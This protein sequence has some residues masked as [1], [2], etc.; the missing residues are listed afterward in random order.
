MKSTGLIQLVGNLHQAGKIHNLRQIC[1]VFGCVL[2]SGMVWYDMVWYGMI[3]DINKQQ[4]FYSLPKRNKL[5]NKIRRFEQR[6]FV[7]VCSLR[8][9]LFDVV[10]RYL[11][12]PQ[13]EASY[14]MALL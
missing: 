2:L 9:L 11:H 8:L 3:I 7:V 13:I 1:G 10:I 4:K 6:L 14:D 12:W 5:N